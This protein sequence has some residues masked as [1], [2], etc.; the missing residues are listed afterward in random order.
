MTLYHNTGVASGFHSVVGDGPGL[1]TDNS[2]NNNKNS[3]VFQVYTGLIDYNLNAK[4]DSADD[5]PT[6]ALTG[7]L[8]NGAATV[9]GL[10]NTSSLFV[11][12]Y[13]TGSGLPAGTQVASI[14]NST[15]ITLTRAAT[16]SGGKSL[17]FDTDTVSGYR[18]INGAVDLNHD[19]AISS[20]D[21]TKTLA[22]HPQ[23]NGFN[24]ISGK[25]DLNG[26]GKI[27][28]KDTGESGVD[29]I[30]TSPTVINNAQ[31]SISGFVFL[32]NGF[33][34]GPLGSVVLTLTGTT[35]TGQQ[36]TYSVMS[37]DD[38]SYSFGNL[39]A[40]TYTITETLPPGDTAE[41]ASAGTVNDATDGAVDPS[42][43]QIFGITLGDSDAGINYDF[44]T[45]HIQNS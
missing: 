3:G 25:I 35:S 11:G 19:G 24:V 27:D 43:T 10:S 7:T 18:V 37:N 23:F 28:S 32:D 12:E 26:N 38:G 8:T 5:T 16:V 20:A 30:C 4:I 6:L 14:I 42:F 1:N 41:S 2:L 34:T 31:A 15:T 45:F 9:T 36:V 21:T 33:V 13:V 39:E 44:T 22:S 29:A 17:T 40:G